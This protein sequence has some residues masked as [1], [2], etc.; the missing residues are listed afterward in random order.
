MGKGGGGG[1]P[2]VGHTLG[3][4][5]RLIAC[6]ALPTCQASS[7]RQ[8]RAER[9]TRVAQRQNPGD[10]ED[11]VLCPARSDP[12][13]EDDRD[14]GTVNTATF[15]R[16]SIPTCIALPLRQPPSPRPTA[17]MKTCF[18]P[19]GN[20]TLLSPVPTLPKQIRQSPLPLR[21]VFIVIDAQ[22]KP[23]NVSKGNC[24]VGK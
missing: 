15:S 8:R 10:R 11:A 2:F 22:W 6:N 13:D 18:E 14:T 3:P 9:K 5:W 16:T 17:K 4:P 12:H 20:N 24:A 1:G 7:C 21:R 23:V 19:P